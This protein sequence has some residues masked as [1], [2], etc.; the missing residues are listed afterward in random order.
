V[1]ALKDAYPFFAEHEASTD[2]ITPLVI[3]TRT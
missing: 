1:A 2:R 3:L